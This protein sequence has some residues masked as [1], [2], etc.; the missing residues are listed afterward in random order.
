MRR[1]R[2]YGRGMYQVDGFPDTKL[3]RS[4]G[5]VVFSRVDVCESGDCHGDDVPWKCLVI[6]SGIQAM[7]AHDFTNAAEG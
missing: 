3:A 4:S 6:L 2:V 7:A 1:T 5:L